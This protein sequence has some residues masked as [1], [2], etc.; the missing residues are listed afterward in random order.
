MVA[1]H[2][3]LAYLVYTVEDIAL[4]SSASS[5]LFKQSICNLYCRPTEAK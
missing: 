3:I 1:T 4:H 2:W 5:G